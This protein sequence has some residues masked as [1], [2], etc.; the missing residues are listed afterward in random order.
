MARVYRDRLISDLNDEAAKVKTEIELA[1][2]Q[3]SQLSMDLADKGLQGKAYN[4]VQKHL[5]SQRLVAKSHYLFFSALFEAVQRHVNLAQGLLLSDKAC[6][7]V[8]DG[9]LDDRIRRVTALLSNPPQ[10]PSTAE[11]V[12][13][14]RQDMA[15]SSE[16][17]YIDPTDGAGSAYMKTV[18]ADISYIRFSRAALE[19][20]LAVLQKIWTVYRDYTVQQRDIYSSAAA[21][22]SEKGMLSQVLSAEAAAAE[23]NG[24]VFPAGVRDEIDR[25][26]SRQRIKDA[27]RIIDSRVKDPAQREKLKKA[28]R[29]IFAD[30]TVGAPEIYDKGKLNS[31]NCSVLALLPR[32]FFTAADVHNIT[33]ALDSMYAAKDW[34]AL[35]RFVELQIPRVPIGPGR[36]SIDRPCWKYQGSVLLDLLSVYA[37]SRCNNDAVFLKDEKYGKT[38]LDHERLASVIMQANS[39]ASKSIWTLEGYNL[40][41][42]FSIQPGKYKKDEADNNYDAAYVMTRFNGIVGEKSEIRHS[43][44]GS[45]FRTVSLGIVGNPQSVYALEH[46]LIVGSN[47]E[48]IGIAKKTFGSVTDWVIGEL[49]SEVIKEMFG[50]ASG[51]SYVAGFVAALISAGIGIHDAQVKKEE[52]E[53]FARKIND[54]TND[55]HGT[56][57]AIIRD[58][59]RLNIYGWSSGTVRNHTTAETCNKLYTNTSLVNAAIEEYY[60][61]T[62]VRVD[63]NDVM[64][65]LVGSLKK[66]RKQVQEFMKW[67]MRPAKLK[68]MAAGRNPD[69]T[70]HQVGE[71]VPE[72]NDF[73]NWFYIKHPEKFEGQTWR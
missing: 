23:G 39:M 63:F 45:I 10:I 9:Q 1:Q 62:H 15:N 26:F 20:L 42:K 4:A 11:G 47:N 64:N 12:E 13:P 40:K 17:M 27:D 44:T 3:V 55:I 14:S 32:Y 16:K 60:R 66:N 35:S 38:I 5:D 29:D 54:K 33:A 51:V 53:R 72:D 58:D 46:F 49:R 61:R 48:N 36:K 57:R 70:M 68:Y 59:S 67:L 73:T 2:K 6:G 41:F 24:W 71:P 21:M 56:K 50:G 37:D 69:G 18:D 34:A 8:D 19:R 7:F 25:A 30:D 52:W 28:V 65:N 31:I 43:D 22:V